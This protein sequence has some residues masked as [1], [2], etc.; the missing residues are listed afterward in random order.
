MDY[1]LISIET[2]EDDACIDKCCECGKFKDTGSVCDCG[3]GHRERCEECDV[4]E[5]KKNVEYLEKKLQQLMEKITASE[6][7]IKKK[8]EEEMYS[9]TCDCCGIQLSID[10]PIMCYEG[11]KENSNAEGYLCWDKKTLCNDCYWDEGYWNDDLN[12]DNE[13][14]IDDFK[15]K[16]I[17]DTLC[18]DGHLGGAWGCDFCGEEGANNLKSY[19][20]ENDVNYYNAVY[21]YNSVWNSWNEKKKEE[22]KKRKK[23]K[24]KR[25]RLV[26]IDGER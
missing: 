25:K 15:K 26:I 14:E 5:A 17:Y 18:G 4:K 7:E 24:M 12:S 20:E 19:L 6:E 13:D 3:V 23:R 10:V 2:K 22:R 1:K 21:H 16:N 8:E 11:T 9:A